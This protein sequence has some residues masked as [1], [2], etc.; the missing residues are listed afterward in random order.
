MPP[1]TPTSTTLPASLIA[2]PPPSPPPLACPRPPRGA[3]RT[4]PPPHE[5][6]DHVDD[7]L[8]RPEAAVQD[9]VIRGQVVDVDPVEGAVALPLAGPSLPEVPLGRLH[10]DPLPLRHPRGADGPL[11]PQPHLQG[12]GPPPPRPAGSPRRTIRRG[13]ARPASDPPRG[14][15]RDPAPP[16]GSVPGRTDR[17]AA[18][19]P[20]RPRPPRG[21]ATPT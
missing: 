5:E 14:R 15:G 4:L 10:R 9:Q 3:V 7:I 16:G 1:V 13:P 20:R 12:P 6:R 19:S 2:S 11:R 18:P 8:R 21:S 17:A